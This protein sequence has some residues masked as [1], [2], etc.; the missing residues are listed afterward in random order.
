MYRAPEVE[1]RGQRGQV[2]GVVI[3]V[4]AVIG[5]GGAPMTAP[6]V[7][8]DAIA[9]LDEEQHLHV[10]IVGRQRP[11][12]AEH[13]RLTFAPVLVEDLDAVLGGDLVHLG[14]S[15]S[16]W[17]APYAIS[18]TLS[19]GALV[20]G[21]AAFAGP[22]RDPKVRDSAAARPRSWTSNPGTF[23]AAVRCTHFMA[24]SRNPEC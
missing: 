18:S 14:A 22:G 20:T 21:W 8:D 16:P 10:P 17:F 12:V 1:M 4:V 3:H 19:A 6:V 24:S 11:A 7:G 5:L 13:D 15:L 2:V 9:V 23:S